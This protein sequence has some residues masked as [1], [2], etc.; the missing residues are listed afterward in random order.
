MTPADFDKVLERYLQDRCTEA[1][2]LQ[3]EAWFNAMGADQKGD[4]LDEIAREQL[5]A[6]L[7]AG[8]DHRT[9]GSGRKRFWL[10]AGGIAATITFMV[11]CLLVVSHNFRGNTLALGEN[12][13]LEV[14]NTTG[15]VQK[16]ALADGSVV[17]LEPGS[18]L[19]Y[20]EKFGAQREVYLT[21][22]AFFDVFRDEKHPFLV[23]AEDVVTRVLG[24]SFRVKAYGQGNEVRVAVTSGKVSVFKKG[25]ENSVTATAEQPVILTPNQEA[26]FD[27]QEASLTKKLVE[28]PQIIEKVPSLKMSYTNAS[29]A[30]VFDALEKSYG[31]D[32]QFDKDDLQGCTITTDLAEEGLY[33]RVEILCHV[34]D[35]EYRVEGTTIII[36]ANGCR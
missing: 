16:V 10:M 22:E 26:V 32:I 3:V 2:K 4:G 18:T 25:S 31:V 6:K 21:G 24:T 1:E 15:S 12:G 5:K 11:V 33:E 9:G 27:K 13:L 7:W 8:V 29:V 36:T 17:S 20:P 34:L 23:Y 19:R 14:E 28:A 35:A 30:E